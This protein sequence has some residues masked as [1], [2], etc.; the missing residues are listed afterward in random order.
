MT[1]AASKKDIKPF[2]SLPSHTPVV[3][4]LRG[5][6]LS[7]ESNAAMVASGTIVATMEAS[8]EES[9]T[10]E[11]FDVLLQQAVRKNKDFILARV[12]TQ[13]EHD[14]LK[15]FHSIYQAHHMN[16]VLFRTQPEE[17]L[18]HRM[19][20]RNPLNNMVIVGDVHYFVI[21]PLMARETLQRFSQANESI[22]T[23]R[24]MH[25][26]RHHAKRLS[27]DDISSLVDEDLTCL[28]TSKDSGLSEL[29]SSDSLPTYPH[30]L[31][32]QRSHSTDRSHRRLKSDERQCLLGRH[33]SA[34]MV[35]FLPSTPLVKK[36]AY[37]V[38]IAFDAMFYGT[39]DDFL[40]KASVREYFKANSI[41]ENDYVLFTL[42]PVEETTIPMPPM[43]R[44]ERPRSWRNLYGLISRRNLKWFVLLYMILC[45][46]LIKFVVPAEFAYLT[47]FLL[48]F[49][50]AFIF[51][52]LIECDL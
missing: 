33:T 38:P 11:T 40:M 51:V 10:F 47:G 16:K 31:F 6:P 1:V 45:V 20:A 41:E 18:L 8:E 30:T 14:A 48:I 50:L 36:D 7:H 19:K 43:V 44:E 3:I 12:T 23:S 5:G 2:F 25:P 39:D 42:Y 34:S 24:E 21:T 26:R 32:T 29:C 46:L 37:H 4:R 49:F 22:R 17:G 52:V 9:F 13:D 27:A 15:F 35:D 28:K